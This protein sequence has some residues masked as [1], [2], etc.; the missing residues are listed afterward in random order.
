MDKR[1]DCRKCRASVVLPFGGY[2]DTPY[3]CPH[4]EAQFS[5]FN[6]RIVKGTISEFVRAAKNVKKLPDNGAFAFRLNRAILVVA[7]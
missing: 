3:V 6:D 1:L 2:R 4:C 5:E 7:Q